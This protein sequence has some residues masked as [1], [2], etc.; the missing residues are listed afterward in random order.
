MVTI[1]CNK[2]GKKYNKEWIFRGMDFCIQPGNPTVVTGFNGSGKSTLLQC[3]SGSSLLTEGN[4][5]FSFNDSIIV[6]EKHFAY[7]SLVAPY[8]DIVEEMTATEFLNFHQHF[9]PFY[10]AITTADALAMAG[11]LKAAN[12]QIRY[13]SSGMKQ[14]IKLLQ[15]VLSDVPLLL[16]DEPCT[17]LDD[18]GVALY[19]SLVDAYGKQKTI[20]V[21]SNNKIEYSF[22]TQQLNIMQFKPGYQ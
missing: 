4:I 8:L 5:V 22:C 6:A 18:E 16:L 14:R 11:L 1:T 15:A 9:K 19:H 10:T 20:L 3:V 21:A 12:K 13:F 2:G 7:C 17:N